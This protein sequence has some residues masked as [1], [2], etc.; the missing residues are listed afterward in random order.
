MLFKFL[1]KDIRKN[2]SVTVVLF[3]FITLAAILI[4]SGIR[5]LVSTQNSIDT[6]FKNAKSIDYVQMVTQK[7]NEKEL[8]SFVQS[9]DGILCQQTQEMLGIDNSN[10]YYGR[11]M[12]SAPDS[13]MEYSF[14]TQ[15]R[16][17]DY[18]LNM[19]N[20]PVQVGKGEIGI[21]IYVMET[22][23]LQVGQPLII[24]KG[25]FKMEFTTSCYVRDSQ[26]NPSMVS[27]KR[28]VISR[29]DY[30]ILKNNIGETEYL[31]AFLLADNVNT[32]TLESE[33]LAAGLP[34]GIGYD[35]TVLRLMNILSSGIS[36]AILA[37]ISFIFIFISILCLRFIVLAALEEEITEIGVMKAIGIHPKTIC[38]LYRIKY[39]SIAATACFAGFLLSLALSPLITRSV[40]LYMGKASSSPIQLVCPAIGALFVFALIALSCNLML[41]KTRKITPVTAM[42]GMY[43]EK[44][45][46]VAIHWKLHQSKL[47]NI[48]ILLG[49][50]DVFCRFQL[51]FI[52][53]V[54]LTL[55][56]FIMI[57]PIN[58]LTT[59]TSPDFTRYSGAGQS[60]IRIDLRH[61]EDVRSRFTEMQS[62]LS[63][64]TDIAQFSCSVIAHYRV[65][66][67]DGSF[68]S[69]QVDNGDFSL[70][71]LEYLEGKQPVNDSE[72][73]LSYLNSEN[74]Q[75]KTGDVLEVVV[76]EEI[77]KLTVSGV[78]QDL[79]FGGRTAKSNLPWQDDNA[80]WYK[81]HINLVPGTS[82][83]SKIAE[84][85]N[86]FSPAKIT[87]IEEYVSQ[88]FST[89]VQQVKIISAAAIF[90]AAFVCFLILSLFYK[91]LLAKDR[92]EIRTQKR[93]GFTN[94]N[95][96]LR[97]M[98]SSTVILFVSVLIGSFLAIVLGEILMGLMLSGLGII[99]VRFIINIGLSVILCPFILVLSALV[100]TRLSTRV[101]QT[102]GGC[103]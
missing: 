16:D 85:V 99:K 55:S 60:D 102:I 83:D 100:A 66:T 28:F 31:V 8:A 67:K 23:G 3:L 11:Q 65:K 57:V 22:M 68:E 43:H 36:L 27:S 73:A 79:T 19:D 88:T 50:R 93:L 18:L 95:L 32:T 14:V 46:S 87:G 5:L 2:I 97:Y 25:D 26:M 71:P 92:T 94:T 72:I 41:R 91:M 7:P 82:I 4:S 90:I 29:E 24:Q 6:F 81:I 64:D 70:F 39:F 10:I 48:H 103:E 75:K 89:T 51:Y 44:K 9:Q 78:Y 98:S 12:T 38:K 1:K 74:L 17:F 69:F 33:Y 53:F 77:R 42:Q 84:Y 76:E 45:D 15:N 47:S 37:F 80:L 21:P 20:R 54:V 13:V 63:N 58:M 34:H 86:L 40:Q 30:T 96:R 59:I 35:R 61:S 62:T 101:I 56:S 52:P 49:I